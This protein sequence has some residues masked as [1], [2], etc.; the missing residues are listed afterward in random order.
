M[1]LFILKTNNDLRELR[2]LEDRVGRYTAQQFRHFHVK[3]ASGF[4][5][6]QNEKDFIIKYISDSGE[7]IVPIYTYKKNRFVVSG[8]NIYTRFDKL[9]G[10]VS[11]LDQAR[12]AAYYYGLQCHLDNNWLKESDAYRLKVTEG[13]EVN[14]SIRKK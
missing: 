12:T 9:L 13:I 11:K 5:Q 2:D 7:Y 4:A 6:K 10:R 8:Y 14:K 1:D 3:Y